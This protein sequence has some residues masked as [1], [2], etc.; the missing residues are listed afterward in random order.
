[1]DDG[2]AL[3]PVLGSEQDAGIAGSSEAVCGVRAV[4]EESPPP[5]WARVRRRGDAVY[6]SRGYS[7]FD[8]SPRGVSG[9]G[10]GDQNVCNQILKLF[11]F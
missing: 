11:R 3:S 8:F 6:Y 5:R 2:S 1:M 7:Y 9:Q 10:L 4:G